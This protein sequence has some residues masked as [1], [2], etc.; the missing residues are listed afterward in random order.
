MNFFYQGA[1][2]FTREQVF[3]HNSVSDCWIIIAVRI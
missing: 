2:V 3:E 1:R